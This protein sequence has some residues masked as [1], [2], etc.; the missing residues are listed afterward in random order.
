MT[1]AATATTIP[2]SALTRQW[3]TTSATVTLYVNSVVCSMSM[4]CRCVATDE[5]SSLDGRGRSV[6][7]AYGMESY[8][9]TGLWR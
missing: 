9:L 4:W 8:C 1:S 3:G 6:S 2:A 7:V 5:S